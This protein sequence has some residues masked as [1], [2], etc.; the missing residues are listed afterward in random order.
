[1]YPHLLSPVA[2]GPM[3]LRN[4]IVMAPMGVEIVDADGHA[5]EGII[6]YYEE[7]ARGGVGLIVT[8]VCAMAYPRGANSVHQLGLSDDSFVPDL[9]RLTDRV[10]EHGAKIAIQLVHHG[11][12]SR[13]D[14]MKGE[15]VL[16]P[17]VPEWHGS[18]DMVN[19]LTPGELGLMAAANGGAVPNFRAMTRDDIAWVVDGFAAA[20]ARAKA[21]GFDG[22]EIH[23]AH[24]Y[25]ISGFLSRQFNRRDD[26]YGGDVENRSRLLCEVLTAARAAVGDDIALWCRLDALEYRTPDGIVFED[27]EVTAQLAVAAGADAIHLSAYGDMTSGPAFTEGTLPHREAKHAALSARL[28]RTLDVPVIAVGRI[29]PATGD[30]MIA[31]GKADLIAMGRQML[32]DPA[33]ARKLT[34]GREADVRPC[35]NCYTC[36]AQPF[37][38]QRVRCAVNPVLADE[39][40][41]ADVER[42]R[43]ADP[44]RVV[45]VGGGPAGMEAARVAILRGH[46][47]TLFEAGPHL[48]GSLR[49]AALVYEPN[50]R[51]LEW[52]TGQ[53]EELGVDVRLATPADPA[54]VADLA[55]D[56]VIVATGAA[57]E[58][59]AIPGADRPLVVDGDDLRALLTGSGDVEAAAAKLSTLGRL[60]VSVGRRLG[61]TDDAGRLARLTRYYMP[62]GSRVVIV[63]GGLVGIE[64]AE[65]LVDRDREVTVLEAGA[66]MATEM[67]HP[68]RWRV[69]TDL[70]DEGATLVTGAEVTEI[71]DDR[72]R[73]RVGSGHDATD[74]EVPVDTVVIATGLVGDESVADRFREAGLDP[75]VIGDCTGVG[76][77]EG[78]IHD[79]FRAAVALG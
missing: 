54:A 1:M 51:L 16:V 23:G 71:L 37:F 63:G 30:E 62:V 67:A 5:N 27:T 60:S 32:A 45:I 68:R 43:A 9:R 75:V 26:E 52:L 42:T 21:A 19:D 70:R 8:E 33:T 35:I 40:E 55:P 66:T 46:R 53:M 34:E 47:V 69:L 10:H 64:L 44:K 49:F 31:N 28:K 78:A 14:T 76:Y 13:V 20:A 59:A 22:V 3:A 74:H 41:L 15:D 56:R 39:V 38:D 2:I 65:F 50:L 7:R 61:L 12:I 73:Y 24:G 79:G 57:R 4:R 29:R 72:V 11:K 58:R 36:V 77:L 25:L 17:S 6:A 18:L 48:G